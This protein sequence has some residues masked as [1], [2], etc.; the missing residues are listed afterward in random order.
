MAMPLVFG[1]YPPTSVAPDL[2]TAS[3]Y[4]QPSMLPPLV[5]PHSVEN[6][7]EV[8]NSETTETFYSND[9]YESEYGEGDIDNMESETDNF[10]D[11]EMEEVEE[12]DDN[13]EEVQKRETA[14]SPTSCIQ[15]SVQLVSKRNLQTFETENSSE[16]APQTRRS[17]RSSNQ[18]IKRKS[19]PSSMSSKSGVEHKS[20]VKKSLSN[21]D[22]K[23][24]KPTSIWSAT[25]FRRVL[26][27]FSSSPP[28]ASSA[29]NLKR[30]GSSSSRASLNLEKKRK[31]EAESK[32][33]K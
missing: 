21:N 4:I 32:D 5:S 7:L 33:Q 27:P 2:N 11:C 17:T 6:P 1:W 29:S 23:L 26:S 14:G 16:S 12:I 15:P 18:D 19:M 13:D 30:S 3:V 10:F 9:D 8:A 25:S 31:A 20:R 22:L 28:K 24:V